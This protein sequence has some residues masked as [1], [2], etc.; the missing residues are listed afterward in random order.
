MRREWMAALLRSRGL[1][2]DVVGLVLEHC[3]RRCSVCL[4]LCVGGGTRAGRVYCSLACY[5]HV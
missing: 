4:R 2:D 3:E 5:E 1:C